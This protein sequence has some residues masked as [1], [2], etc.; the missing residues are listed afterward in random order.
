VQFALSDVAA[1]VRAALDKSGLAA[2]RLELEITEGVFVRDFEAVTAKLRD[3]RALGVGIALDDF[4]TGY[5]SLSYLGRLPIDKIKIDQSFVRR[6]PA[7]T[8]SAAIIR[9][10]VTLAESLGK[11]IIA[12]GI[13]TTDQA[14]MLQMTGCALGQGYHFGRPLEPKAFAARLDAAAPRLAATA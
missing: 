5:S 12:E 10:V 7:D 9:A 13:E 6:L 2:E 11:Q 14:W 3:I 8:E 1:D 4:G